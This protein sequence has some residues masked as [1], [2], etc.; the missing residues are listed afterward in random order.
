MIKKLAFMI[1]SVLFVVSLA[2]CR[3]E[4]EVLYVLN[5]GEYMDEDLIELFE[6]TY[7]VRIVYTEVGS[8]EA[9]EVQILMDTTP[10][11]IAIPSDY[12]IDKLFQNGLLHPIDPEL[13]PNLANINFIEDARLLYENEPF[14]E[15]MIPYFW[16]TIGIL[17]NTSNPDVVEALETQGWMAL[18]DP[19]SPFNR[20]MYD[21]PRDAVGAALLAL[22]LDVN[23]TNESELAQAEALLREANFQIFGEDNLKREVVAGNLDMAL[24]Y[25]GDYFDELFAADEDGREVN[26]NLY[27]PNSTN[28]WI[29]AFVIPTTA[30][31]IEL[32]HTFINFFLDVDNK[33]ANS[34]WVGYTPVIQEVFDIMVD[35]YEYDDP[36]YFPK[37]EGTARYLFRYISQAHDQKLA[38]ILNRVKLP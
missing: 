21:S 4:Q 24:V 1:L 37:P 38:D 14:A 10:F 5:W 11:D 29:D 22:G 8:N 12:M 2:A 9:M 17:Y 34:D 16:G 3:S 32:A 23:T 31:N 6:E 33:V 27:V 18:F 15:H 30:Q 19:A 28:V 26:F 35:E 25:S 13:L 36:A 20:G 7:N